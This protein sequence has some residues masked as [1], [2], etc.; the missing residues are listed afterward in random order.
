MRR[1][2]AHP[3]E[4]QKRLVSDALRIEGST[5]SVRK[6]ALICLSRT[7]YPDRIVHA[8]PFALFGPI[9]REDG[10]TTPGNVL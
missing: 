8:I 9:D 7:R 4:K 3:H 6:I 1:A 5:V 10:H 2:D